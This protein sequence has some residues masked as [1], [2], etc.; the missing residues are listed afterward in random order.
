MESILLVTLLKKFKPL[1]NKFYERN[2][3]L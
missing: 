2:Y 3:L 1:I